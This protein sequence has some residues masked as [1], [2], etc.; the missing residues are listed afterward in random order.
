MECRPMR[1]RIEIA[2]DVSLEP[3][4]ASGGLQVLVKP[5]LADHPLVCG[6]RYAPEHLSLMFVN[7]IGWFPSGIMIGFLGPGAGPN[8]KRFGS[9]NLPKIYEVRGQFGF[10]SRNFRSDGKIIAKEKYGHLTVERFHRVLTKFE[11]DQRHL[12]YKVAGVAMGTEEAYQA[13]LNRNLVPPSK[14][15]VCPFVYSL[16]PL[17]FKPPEFSIRIE[18]L[19]ENDIFLAEMIHN[20]GIAMRSAAI[21]TSIRLFEHGPFKVE[22]ALLLKHWTLEN[23][24][25]NIYNNNLV[26]NQFIEKRAEDNQVA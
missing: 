5:N 16:K 8:A 18:C 11:A 13:V 24:I 20:I 1:E 7:S 26:Y 2:G 23:V 14:D 3:S 4:S 21:C 25:E 19:N 10:A 22:N 12:M 15:K 17:V 6:P 9:F